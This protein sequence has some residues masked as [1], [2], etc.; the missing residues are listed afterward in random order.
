MPRSA[1]TTSASP[2]RARPT[3]SP[4]RPSLSCRRS[5][6]SAP[7]LRSR[8]HTWRWTAPGRSMRRGSSCS[9]ARSTPPSS[10][11]TASRRPGQCT[12][13]CP[14]QLDPYNV[15]PLWPDAISLAALQAR[16]LLESGRADG[17]KVTESDLAEVA[18]RSRKSALDNPNAQ[19]AWDRP[20][21]ELL[22]DDLLRDPLRL[23]DC[24]PIT[25]GAAAVILA[26]DDTA[27]DICERPAWITG[28]DHRTDPMALGVRDLARSE[29]ARQAAEKAGVGDGTGRRGRA[30]RPVHA[31]GAD[32][33]RRPWVGRRNGGQP[34]GWCAVR[35]PDHG[36]GPGP[37]RRGGP[38][39]HRRRGR[40]RRGSRHPGPVP[41]T[42]PRLRP[43]RGTS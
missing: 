17:R 29:S 5:T 2:A 20:A 6:A 12:R 37:G 30:P 8:S 34:V 33:A 14:R 11:P 16:S 25:D 41:A 38:A 23:H 22:A 19:L 7:G 13:C 32:L 18:A 9:W 36:R 4:A 42:E 24:P 28:I 26:A 40:A 3:T 21:D 15:A 31:P 10:T 27:R 35:P 43:R 39:H 1:R